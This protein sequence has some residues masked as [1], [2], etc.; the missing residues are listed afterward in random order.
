MTLAAVFT[1]VRSLILTL[2][3]ASIIIFL[4]LEVAP[5]DVA[6][7]MMGLDADPEA[8]AALR[9]ELGL[10]GSVFKRYITWIFGILHGD[11]GTSY[12]YRVPVA[13][14]IWDRIQVSMALA[15]MSF[16]LSTLIAIPLAAFA[17]R[18][19]SSKR[20]F[21]L[22][23]LVQIF[24]AIPNF[25]LAIMLLFVFA[26]LLGVFPAGGFPGW[27]SGVFVALKSLVLP[28]IAL[29]LP[30]AAILTRV[31]R[32]SLLETLNADY[33]RT[34]R[35]KGLSKSQSLWRHGLK[36]AL[37]PVLPLMGLQF[38]FLVA[39]AIVI[40]TVFYLPGLGRLVF[41]AIGQRDLIVVKGVVV[42]LVFLVVFISFVTDLLAMWL[43]PRLARK[44][45]GGS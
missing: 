29:A 34:A 18:H 24:V 3:V 2:F 41:Q 43:D 26:T 19:K 44:Q 8:L 27:G 21:V 25:W 45:R 4:M 22:M 32:S 14:L 13:S 6:R 1:R 10:G 12:T 31:L 7:F 35:A 16:A 30:Q 42:I 36:N 40:E 28:A 5:G 37:V 17:A 11:F 9:S 20:E 15:I 38:A 39:G 23:N 33:M